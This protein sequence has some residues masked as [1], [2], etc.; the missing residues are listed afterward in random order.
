MENVWM[1]VHYLR[2]H[3]AAAVGAVVAL[4]GVG[5]LLN[6]KPKFVREADKRLDELRRERSDRYHKVR[7]PR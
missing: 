7:P 4:V 3:P 6:R 2:E 1:L 5:Y